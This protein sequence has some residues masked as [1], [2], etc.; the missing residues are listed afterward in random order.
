MQIVLWQSNRMTQIFT[1]SVIDVKR[2]LRELTILGELEHPSVIKLYSI[3]AVDTFNELYMVMELCDYDLHTLLQK[4]VTLPP[5]DIYKLL[6]SLLCG[7]SYLH[8]AGVWHRDLKPANCLL[9]QGDW[10]IKIGDFGL[11]RAAQAAESPNPADAKRLTRN[12]TDHVVTRY[13]RAP[14]LICLQKNYTEAIDV[15]SV[16]CIFAELLGTQSETQIQDRGP[17][18]CG[19]TC[20]PL[21]P[22][23]RHMF[24]TRLNNAPSDCDQLNLIFNLFG[25]PK[26]AD[27]ALVEQEDAK[28][29]IQSF[30]AREGMGLDTKFPHAEDV[31][32]D[33]LKKMLQLSAKDRIAVTDALEHN[34]FTS[35]PD[36]IRDPTKV[37]RAPKRI[38]LEF[39]EESNLDEKILLIYF[40]KVIQTLHK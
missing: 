14:E 38:T 23:D 6:Y 31:A 34:L 30:A 39:E 10:S 5:Q 32:I 33:L 4:D 12:L 18:F 2:I 24:P 20:F 35:S 28:R 17:L 27:I 29:Y 1:W 8:S 9:S 19:G 7:L 16:G 26:Q 13:W 40:G 36:V 3:E 22:D 21:S 37:R 25:T 15:W 11:S